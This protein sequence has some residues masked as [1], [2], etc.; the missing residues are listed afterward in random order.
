MER[1][2]W[3]H[4]CDVDNNYIDLGFS[5]ANTPILIEKRVYISDIIIPLS[6]CEYHYFAVQGS[7]R[8]SQISLG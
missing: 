6:D 5:T 8:H 3:L 1:R 4:D 7:L 2:L